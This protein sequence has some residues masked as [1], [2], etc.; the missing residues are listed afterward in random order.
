MMIGNI[1]FKFVLLLLE[2]LMYLIHFSAF[3]Q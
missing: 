3:F 1:L 2:C